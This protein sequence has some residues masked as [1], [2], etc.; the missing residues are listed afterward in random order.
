LQDQNRHYWH[1]LDTSQNVKDNGVWV[2]TDKL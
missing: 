1:E 2:L